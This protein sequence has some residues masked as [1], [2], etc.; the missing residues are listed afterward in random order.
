MRLILLL[1]MLVLLPLAALP[2]PV[3]VTLLH[4]NDFHSHFEKRDALLARIQ[5]LRADHPNAI[6]LD[7]GDMFEGKSEEAL[8]TRG[9]AI[10]DF[11]NEADYDGMTFGDNAFDGFSLDD[12]YR[13]IQRFS[14]PVISCNLVNKSNGDP[15]TVPYWIYE[16]GG[17]S[18]GVIG[19][20]DEE[21]VEDAGVIA[22]NANPVLDFYVHHLKNKVDLLVVL[23]HAGLKQDKEFAKEFPL[24]DVIIGGSSNDALDPPETVGDVIVAQ[25]GNHGEYVGVLQVEVDPEANRVLSHQGWLVPTQP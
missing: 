4:T 16:R 22:I 6:L 5:A 25:A 21:S 20:Y 7:A 1:F 11:M 9:Q 13:C 18:V 24:V 19:I 23:S 14:F 10:V 12:L 2:E 8:R 15:I 3:T 17:A